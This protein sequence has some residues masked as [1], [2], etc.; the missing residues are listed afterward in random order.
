MNIAIGGDHAGFAMKTELTARLRAGGHMVIDC[1]AYNDAPSDYPAVAIAVAGSI[2]N[3]RAERGILLCGSGVG[4]SIAANKITGI[5]AALAHDAFSARQAVNDDDANV[6]C[7]GPRVIGPEL[8]MVLVEI[9]LASVFSGT[10]RHRR[11]LA[12]VAA[13]ES[14]AGF[15]SAGLPSTGSPSADA[16]PDG[17]STE[18]G[19]RTGQKS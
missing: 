11:R 19:S 7:L 10:E 5:R 12:M 18:E 14:S 15:P 2:L 17:T 13:I 3:G 1:G 8:A 4:A 9:F 6:I 16:P